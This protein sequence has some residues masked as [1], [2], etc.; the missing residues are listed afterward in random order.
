MISVDNV[1]KCFGERRVLD[2]FSLNVAEGERVCLSGPSGCGKTTLMR[3]IAGLE[4]S[5]SGEII[6]PQEARL[7]VVFQENR[8][9]PWY[10]ALENITAVGVERECALEWLRKVGLAGEHDKLPSE[11]SGGMSRRVAIARAMA[12]G[13]D[14][15]LLDEPVQGL[16]DGTADMVLGVL[17]ESLADKTVIMISHDRTEIEKLAQR[18]IVLDG[19]P[20]RKK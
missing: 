18:V 16:D 15:F 7:S 10:T 3:L 9:L 11:L 19:P 14:I 12:S 17:S 13:G 4:R 5:D 8:L 6:M 20:L 2:G 1:T